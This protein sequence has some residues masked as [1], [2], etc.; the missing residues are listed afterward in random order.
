MLSYLKI[1]ISKTQQSLGNNL[2]G[3][4]FKYSNLA[5]DSIERLR[6]T[7]IMGISGAVPPEHS[8]AI[9]AV[10][11]DINSLTGVLTSIKQIV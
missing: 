10:S 6:C 4:V 3:Y 2:C 11:L 9:G 8:L 1:A 5:Q 7:K